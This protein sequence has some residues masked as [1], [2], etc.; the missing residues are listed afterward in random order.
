MNT[1]V[2]LVDSS[3]DRWSVYLFLL[4]SGRRSSRHLPNNVDRSDGK[5][6]AS[7]LHLTE[8][9]SPLYT[10][11]GGPRGGLFFWG[12]IFPGDGS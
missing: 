8:C 2:S 4:T 12:S 9:T 1:T 5:R 11:E 7:S 6:L 3:M 10:S